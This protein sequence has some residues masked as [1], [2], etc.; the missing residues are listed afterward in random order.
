MYEPD[1]DDIINNE[2]I[3]Y[4]QLKT[5]KRLTKLSNEKLLTLTSEEAKRF[6][7]SIREKKIQEGWKWLQR[8]KEANKLRREAAALSSQVCAQCVSATTVVQFSRITVK[9]IPK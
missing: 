8:V 1:F 6:I 7:N 3:Y 2:P 9:K 4:R 5:L